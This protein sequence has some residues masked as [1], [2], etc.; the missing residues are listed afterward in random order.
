MRF[1]TATGELE[2]LNETTVTLHKSEYW[3]RIFFVVFIFG[4]GTEML[5]FWGSGF[6]IL[7]YKIHTDVK[8]WVGEDTKVELHN[9]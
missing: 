9:G 7:V 4:R 3:R 8:V 6:H 1:S 5:T 2:R